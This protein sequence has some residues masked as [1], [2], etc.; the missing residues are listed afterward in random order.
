MTDYTVH[1]PGSI[2]TEL[3]TDDTSYP[4]S[5]THNALRTVNKPKHIKLQKSMGVTLEIQQKRWNDQLQQIEKSKSNDGNTL[6]TSSNIIL[7]NNTNNLL[8]NNNE[9]IIP[10]NKTKNKPIND[11][12]PYDPNKSQP[13]MTSKP[14]VSILTDDT[15]HIN[16]TTWYQQNNNVPV[17]NEPHHTKHHFDT[18]SIRNSRNSR[19]T[20][21]TSNRHTTQ[22]TPYRSK[23]LYYTDKINTILNHRVYMVISVTLTIIS[24]FLHDMCICWFNKQYDLLIS[25]ILCVIFG[26][27]LIEIILLCI[28]K[29][30]Y[31]NS[32][33]FY[34]DLIGTLSL[35]LDIGFMV[36]LDQ[37]SMNTSNS[38]TSRI[39]QS[40]TIV[41]VTKFARILRV[42][43]VIRVIRIVNYHAYY[44][45]STHGN[46]LLDGGSNGQSNKV[47]LQLSELIDKRVIFM[48]LSVLIVMPLLSTDVSTVPTIDNDT[49]VAV[50]NND[51][52]NPISGGTIQ[53][54]IQQYIT[55]NSPT[56]IYLQYNNNIY[57]DNLVQYQWLRNDEM[58]V[59]YDNNS[60]P[61]LMQSIRDVYYQQS[62]YDMATTL[63][64]IGLF[65]IGSLVITRDVNALVVAPLERMTIVIR[66]LTGTLC[67]LHGSDSSHNGSDGG[68]ETRIIEGMIDKLSHIFAVKPSDVSSNVGQS[69]AIQMMAGSKHTEIQTANSVVSIEVVERPREPSVHMEY[70]DHMDYQY[71]PVDLTLYTEL[72]SID[73][74][75][76]N[77]TVLAH[78]KL[79]MNEHYLSENLQFWSEVDRFRSIMK[80]HVLRLYHSFISVRSSNPI[81]IPA[82]MRAR[83]SVDLDD[84][85]SDIFDLCQSEVLLLMKGSHRNFLD[86]KFCQMYLKQ[87]K[88]Q[89]PPIKHVIQQQLI[90]NNT[91]NSTNHILVQPPN[92]NHNNNTVSGNPELYN[93]VTNH[94]TDSIPSSNNYNDTNN[95]S[96]IEQPQESQS[97]MLYTRS[98]GESYELHYTTQPSAGQLCS[99]IESPAPVYDRLVDRIVSIQSTPTHKS[100]TPI[101]E[102]DQQPLLPADNSPSPDNNDTNQYNNM[103]VQES[104]LHTGRLWTTPQPVPGLAAVPD[105]L[106]IAIN[107]SLPP[108][109]TN[110][111]RTTLR[112]MSA[113][114]T[115]KPQSIDNQSNRLSQDQSDQIDDE[116]SMSN[117]GYSQL[118]LTNP[119][120]A[121]S[122]KQQ[123]IDQY[124]NHQILVTDK[125]D[126]SDET[127]K[128]H[129]TH[130]IDYNRDG[131][132]Q[133]QF[134]RLRSLSQISVNNSP[135]PS[136]SHQPS[137]HNYNAMSPLHSYT[138]Q[139][140]TQTDCMSHDKE[141]Q[142]ANNPQH[143]L[144]RTASNRLIQ[145]NKVVRATLANSTQ[146]QLD[147]E[148]DAISNP[149]GSASLVVPHAGRPVRASIDLS[150]IQHGSDT[151]NN[152]NHHTIQSYHSR[153]QINLF[154]VTEQLSVSTRHNISRTVDSISNKYS[155]IQHSVDDLLNDE[156]NMTYP[157]YSEMCLTNPAKAK[158]IKQQHLQQRTT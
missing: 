19:P 8:H 147:E 57:I 48:M 149:K 148:I 74:I 82:S 25:I 118:C 85:S 120:Q 134:S 22:P 156:L 72:D 26:I 80:L 84:P 42:L 29:P 64:I 52:S 123:Y 30:Q 133:P 6:H 28:S 13:L 4:S 44:Q 79:Y 68:Y 91:L 1:L 95:T 59:Y 131:I 93:T 99:I 73:S 124:I 115:I 88:V 157:G 87:R 77:P 45:Q 111:R 78:F 35:I 33:L 121:K 12:K 137:T 51:L 101:T 92:N 89:P 86:S 155:I 106:H 144:F 90:R 76:H 5:S 127:S 154:N 150:P 53:F 32:Y 18:G 71:M 102:P 3:S 142:S 55:F 108:S 126:Q 11:W 128:L 132:D 69:K 116:L 129:S 43:R 20:S 83:V 119:Q 34:L 58:L 114:N 140:R 146:L 138:N 122:M 100:I 103:N 145:Q 38:N 41:R 7:K 50:L 104:A 17:N 60:S 2:P 139:H 21:N 56:L 67:F 113:I 141:N 158:H 47:G 117:P 65:V 130:L 75:I 153:N 62:Y 152:S 136:R 14:S 54:M 70:I 94:S 63:F 112:S 39:T 143:K 107:T 135:L 66:K 36:N 15:E 37:Y 109:K 31:I 98:P 151:P 110:S 9:H 81:N 16:D 96:E 49:L 24:L 61:M 40:A 27:F 46:D 105:T 10:L 97:N 125:N 23:L